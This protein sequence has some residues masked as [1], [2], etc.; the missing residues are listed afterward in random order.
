M[1][2]G[3]GRTRSQTAAAAAADAAAQAA[4]AQA[5]ADARAAKKANRPS[6]SHRRKERRARQKLGPG[7]TQ[8]FTCNLSYE[9]Y[10]NAYRQD[11]Q[12]KQEHDRLEA[13]LGVKQAQTRLSAQAGG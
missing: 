5:A 8:P 11:L 9:A 12:R 1:R 2:A 3:L 10:T 6:S 13:N 4:A 7:H